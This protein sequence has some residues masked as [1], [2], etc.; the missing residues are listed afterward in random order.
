MSIQM[1][2]KPDTVLAQLAAAADK[3]PV[4]KLMTSVTTEITTTVERA[5]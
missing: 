2:R 4:H 5:A 1:Q 3:C